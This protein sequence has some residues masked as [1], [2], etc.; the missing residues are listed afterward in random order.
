MTSGKQKRAAIMAR[1]HERREQARISALRQ[2]SV[3]APVPCGTVPVE[4][5][6]LAPYNSYGDPRFVRRGY[7]L[8]EP[9]VCRDCGSQ[10]VWTAGQQKWWYEVA[11]GYVYSTA[12]RCLACRRARRAGQTSNSKKNNANNI[13]LKAS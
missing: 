5:S 6:L 12:I 9:F 11:H 13:G 7:Y 3:I 10:Q 1:R 4:P 8:D 2:D